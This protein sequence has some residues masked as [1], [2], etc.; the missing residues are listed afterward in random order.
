MIREDEIVTSLATFFREHPRVSLGPGDDTAIILE[1]PGKELAVSVDSSHEDVHFTLDVLTLREIGHRALAG[2]LSDLAAVGA[3]PITFLVDIQLP[4]R[5]AGRASEI[6]EG[7]E[8]LMSAFCISPC[9]G[10][11][12]RGDKLGLSVVVI[13]EIAKGKAI[14]R[15][16]VQPGDLLVITG[17][18][19]RVRGWLLAEEMGVTRGYEPWLRRLREKFARPWP[20]IRQIQR[21]A[22]DVELHAAIDI[23]DG[24]GVDSWRLAIAS[25]VEVVIDINRLPIDDSVKVI[26]ERA[27][28]PPWELALE[29]GEEY[30]V[31]LAISPKDE[32]WLSKLNFP[33]TVVGSA[34]EGR[35]DSRIIVN[36]TEKSL[37]SSGY[38]HFAGH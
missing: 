7:M 11:L 10:N 21:L 22:M 35:P 34:R 30:E 18:I 12:S 37:A 3:E 15:R 28:K 27:K 1:I 38:D 2:A 8:E 29:S 24:L 20:A 5:L 23:S 6:Y 16:G 33:A 13:G 36:G 26:A 25:E 4:K 17:D 31:L 9:G 32:A 19:G 14:T